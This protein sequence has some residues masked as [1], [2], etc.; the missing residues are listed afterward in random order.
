MSFADQVGEVLQLLFIVPVAGPPAVLLLGPWL[1]LVLLLAA[2]TALLITLALVVVV[3]AAVVVVLIGLPYLVVRRL[4][5][6]YSTR[7]RH[8][9]EMRGQACAARAIPS[10]PVIRPTVSRVRP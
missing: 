9:A 4:H 7:R 2:P 6:R 1:G 3:A 10:E 5:A 8:L